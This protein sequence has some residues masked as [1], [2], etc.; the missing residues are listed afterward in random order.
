M[1]RPL[2]SC[3]SR[4]PSS[5]CSPGRALACRPD[6]APLTVPE[7]KPRCR[8]PAP[9]PRRRHSRRY[10]S[11]LH[12]RPEYTTIE[13]GPRVDRCA[14]PGAPWNSNG[15]D[16]PSVASSARSSAIA[17]PG[18]QTAAGGRYSDGRPVHL[19]KFDFHSTRSREGQPIDKLSRCH[20]SCVGNTRTQQQKM[21]SI[22]RSIS[23]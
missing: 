4:H 12:S 3:L 22:F 23:F 7:F 6:V 15:A 8:A 19:R 1:I 14:G 20:P 5:G 21:A 9:G 18:A 2:R 13:A 11:R 16:Y 17:C 10:L